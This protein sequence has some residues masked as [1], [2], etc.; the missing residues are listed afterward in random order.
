MKQKVAIIGLSGQ[1]LM[2]KVH[3]FPA[4][5][6][7]IQMEDLHI[8]PGGKGYNQ[9]IALARLGVDV[10]ILSSVGIDEGASIC[11]KVLLEHHIKACLVEKKEAKTAL[12]TVLTNDEGENEVC[13]YLGASVYLNE[14]DLTM[15]ASE[16]KDS[17][18]ILMQ[19]EQPLSISLKIMELAQRYHV[20]II[21]NPAPAIHYNDDLL[22]GVDII[23]PNEHEASIL[24]GFDI[25]DSDRVM[26]D[27]LKAKGLKRAIVT[28]GKEGALLLEEDVKHIVAPSV[29]V[30]DTVGAG[31]AF[32]AG[33]VYGLLQQYDLYKAISFATIV[34]SISTTKPHVI[35]SYPTLEEV[36]KWAKV[37]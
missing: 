24:F 12:A 37:F 11:R 26:I 23:T 8:E 32:N 21:L 5:G 9:A 34:A 25:C 10:S 31:D 16:I 14:N 17:S 22:Q 1:S 15:F 28:L 4:P 3:H 27:K 13:V 18:Y 33:F 19:L 36:I 6:E 2:G 20:P 30:I 29:P 35:D 7:T